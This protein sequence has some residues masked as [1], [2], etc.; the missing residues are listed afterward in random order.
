MN[1][2]SFARFRAGDPAAAPVAVSDYAATAF[3]AAFGIIPDEEAA[4]AIAVRVLV[5]GLTSEDVPAAG[6]H[7]ERT[8]V[9]ATARAAALAAVR[10]H[11]DARLQSPPEAWLGDLVDTDAASAAF[12]GLPPP[13]RE[14][15][16]LAYGCG[17]PVPELAGHLGHSEDDARTLLERGLFEMQRQLA[18]AAR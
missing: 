7:A 15:L 18:E 14:A 6:P 3:L 8:W 10:G 13:A 2:G 17:M 1:S 4:R 9:A 12:A 11:A 16:G 5:E